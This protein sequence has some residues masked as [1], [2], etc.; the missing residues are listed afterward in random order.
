MQ[1]CH[2]RSRILQGQDELVGLLLL[3]GLLRA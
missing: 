1:R 3:H 2:G